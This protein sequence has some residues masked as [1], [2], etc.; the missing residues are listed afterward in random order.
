MS[1]SAWLLSSRIE[2]PRYVNS[3]RPASTSQ[4][5]VQAQRLGFGAYSFIGAVIPLHDGDV[6]RV[7]DAPDSF[8]PSAPRTQKKANEVNAGRF[9]RQS[10]RPRL[11]AFS[12]AARA[13]LAPRSLAGRSALTGRP[14]LR[15]AE[16]RATAS[17]RR[18]GR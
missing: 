10:F 2:F 18:S 4:T 6:A 14:A 16:A 1:S 5:A 15:M 13:A 17:W 3:S 8:R 12:S 11:Y 7:L 9:P